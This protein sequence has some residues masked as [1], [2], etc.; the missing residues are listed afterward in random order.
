MIEDHQQAVRLYRSAVTNVVDAELR[1]YAATTMPKIEAH[2]AHAQ[3]LAQI[4]E[5]R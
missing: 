2:L 5:P 3:A 4:A 1:G